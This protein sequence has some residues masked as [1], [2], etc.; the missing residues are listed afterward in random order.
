VTHLYS[1]YGLT[2]ESQ[3]EIPGL[4]DVLPGETSF[5]SCA[6]QIAI[7]EPPDWIGKSIREPG[8]A[9][10]P[11]KSPI[12]RAP[13]NVLRL[14]LR[15]E[16]RL[17]H[18]VYPDG[19]QFAVDSQTRCVWGWCPATLTLEDLATYLVGPVMG[20][21][22]RQ[23]GILALHA[24]CFAFMGNAFA[25]CGG[26]Q[27][28]K[29]TAA[30]ALSLRS[31]P[32]LCED[33]AALWEC[34]SVFHVAPGYRRINLWPD[35]ASSLLGSCDELPRITPNWEKRFLPLEGAERPFENQAR[36]LS[37]I[38]L[39]A[40]REDNERAPRIESITPQNALLLLVQ[41]TYMNYLLEKSQRALEL[42]LLVR[43]LSGVAVRRLVPHV[44]PARIGVL[45]ELLEA[46]ARRA[47]MERGLEEFATRTRP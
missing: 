3:V 36:P 14:Y 5:S 16:G 12:Y 20:F 6:I 13:P 42:D 25:L 38:Y 11:G 23:R 27:S 41:N 33:I 40:S 24:S 22:L 28:G 34:D 21:I 47:A 44:D 4:V 17:F 18:L 31:I 15:D 32:I 46:D 9:H 7:G 45:C 37:A 2:F 8:E 43:V 1:A 29:S 26:P 39:F 35:S 19:A 30:A 10:F